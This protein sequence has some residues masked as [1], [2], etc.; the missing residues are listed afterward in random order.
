LYSQFFLD[1]DWYVRHL[2]CKYHNQSYMELIFLLK[3][4]LTK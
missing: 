1:T 4:I 2:S 3:L